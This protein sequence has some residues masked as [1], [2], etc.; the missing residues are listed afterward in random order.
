MVFAILQPD[1]L[2][3][4]VTR[5]LTSSWV[6]QQLREAFPFDAGPRFLI[7]DRKS[8][9]S[10]EVAAA[11]RSLNVRPVRTSL[12]SPWQNGIAERWVKSCRRDVLYQLIPL[13]EAHLKR[14]LTEHVDYYHED[15]THLGLKKQTPGNRRSRERGRIMA[16]PRC[17]G[18]HHR[19]ERAA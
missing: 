7:F 15:L 4:K 17:G 16:L 13:N 3:F 11:I 8:K 6:I 2:H 5:H 1:V 18:L 12:E 10:I 9:F 14:L 19:Y